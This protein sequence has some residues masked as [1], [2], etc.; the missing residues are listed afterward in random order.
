LKI[1]YLLFFTI[2]FSQ[3]GIDPAWSDAI[4]LP[5]YNPEGSAKGVVGNNIVITSEEKIIIFYQEEFPFPNGQKRTYI[6]TSNNNGID[7]TAPILFSP[8][9]LVNGACCPNVS[10][11]SENNVHVIWKSMMPLGIFYSKMDQDQNIIIDTVLVSNIISQNGGGATIS[12]DGNDRIHAFWY[13]GSIEL[14]DETAEI[15]Y[16]R[17]IDNGSSW[18][19][20]YM[21][22][23][24]DGLNS[25]FARIDF[26]GAMGDTLAVAWR[27]EVNSNNWDI[28]MALSENGGQSWVIKM[29]SGGI[30]KQWDPGMIV[31][32]DNYLHINYHEVPGGNPYEANII[33]GW[34]SDGGDNWEPN[35]F[36]QIS[37]ENIRSNLTA[38]AYDYFNDYI[39]VFWKDQRDGPA[40]ADVMGAFSL[41]KGQSWNSPEFVSDLGSQ[42]LGFKSTACS[43]NGKIAVNFDEWDSE[44]GRGTIYYTQRT[45]INALLGDINSDGFINVIDIVS[46]V[47]LILSD[48]YNELGDLNSDGNIDVVD[49]VLI[50][51]L[52]I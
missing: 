13:D 35:D 31:D 9:E 47:N 23:L 25:A 39:W 30:G 44:T 46:T 45:N 24:D 19:T 34:S 33:T 11:D 32:K 15:M 7:W 21:I 3:H 18:E 43:P 52:I 17:S 2:I 10:I 40:E 28:K 16:S 42:Q 49:I 27:N 41:D 36:I 29:V 48:E 37:P 38:F 5:K 50:V 12:V 22:S 6:T 51:N 4:A 1:L 8:P 20:A 26:S 14:E